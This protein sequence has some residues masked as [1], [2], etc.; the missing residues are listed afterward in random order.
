[1]PIKRKTT[2]K[3]KKKPVGRKLFDGK[4]EKV[5]IP[6]LEQAFSIGCTND[7]ACI[8]AGISTSALSRY[9]QKNNEFR[10]RKTML[11]EKL[12][13]ASRNTISQI[14]TEREFSKG[15]N[16]GV[17]TQRAVEMSKWF[18]E[19]KKKDEFGSHSSITAEVKTEALSEEKKR[20]IMK[21]IKQWK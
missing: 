10:V 8:Q 21:R 13:L 19:R 7:E 5:V 3:I 9:E 4:G 17:P 6:K 1:M 16:K 15:N 2:E 11:K 18:L 20:A 12:V 14:I